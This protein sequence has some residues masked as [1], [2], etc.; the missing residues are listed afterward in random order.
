M[1][2]GGC[3]QIDKV[4]LFLPYAYFDTQVTNVPT[5]VCSQVQEPGTC[6]EYIPAWSYDHE[7]DACVQFVYGGCDG[8]D[9]RFET[10]QACL[11]KCS[12]SSKDASG[13][14]IHAFLNY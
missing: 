8:N 3:P 10:E 11:T 14:G 7:T 6:L 9:N 2:V 4:R 12:A 1:V 13:L 5:D